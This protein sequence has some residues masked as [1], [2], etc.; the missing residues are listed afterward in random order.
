MS[1]MGPLPTLIP[2]CLHISPGSIEV[3][4]LIAYETE[5]P[6]ASEKEVAAV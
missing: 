3:Y 5:D 6:R 2:L 1:G 4:Y